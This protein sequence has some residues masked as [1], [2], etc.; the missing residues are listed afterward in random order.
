MIPLKNYTSTVPAARTISVIESYLAE[1]GV[2][3]IAKEYDYGRCVA[4]MFKSPDGRTVKLP[5]D[6]SAVHDALWDDY[7]KHAK[8][9][10]SVHG[11]FEDQAERTAWKLMEDWVRVQM[12]L[13]RLGKK[14]FMEVFLAH[15]WDG[16][17]TFY[18][19]L[20]EQQFKAL[21]APKE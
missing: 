15:I 12:T 2:S 3:G 8:R 14:D 16:K 20:K 13:I 10:R 21:P 1:C 18:N 7:K 9:P 11:D 6:V 17:Q 19:F 5:A 4:L